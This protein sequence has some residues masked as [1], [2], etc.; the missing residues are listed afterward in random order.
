MIPG[1]M[2]TE[3]GDIEIN[4]GRERVTLAVANRGDR[5]IQVGSH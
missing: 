5:P 4:V 1:E 2:R 3:D